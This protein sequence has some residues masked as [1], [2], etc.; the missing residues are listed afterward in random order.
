MTKKDNPIR[1]KILRGLELSH[2][3]LIKSKLQQRNAEL[4]EEIIVLIAQLTSS[5]IRALSGTI[6]QVVMYKEFISAHLD[7]AIVRSLIVDL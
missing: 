1:E 4:P 6:N 3:K 5:D 2:K 7:T